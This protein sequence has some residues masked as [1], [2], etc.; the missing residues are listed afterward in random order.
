MSLAPAT[1]SGPAGLPCGWPA[2]PPACSWPQPA[3]ATHPTPLEALLNSA[4]TTLTMPGP[5]TWPRT[6]QVGYEGVRP[7]PVQCSTSRVV[8]ACQWS[9][10]NFPSAGGVRS[11]GTGS[12]PTTPRPLHTP[13]S[14]ACSRRSCPAGPCS[15]SYSWRERTAA[16]L[17]GR[18][19][20]RQGRAKSRERVAE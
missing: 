19:A 3:L 5:S 2:R 4:S 18:T 11:C 9:L 14:G 12:C 20:Q 17:M 7:A 6:A 10:G 8:D 16:R 1:G 13:A 15:T